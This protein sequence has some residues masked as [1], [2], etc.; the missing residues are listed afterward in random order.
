MSRIGFLF[1]LLSSQ[2][3]AATIVPFERGIARISEYAYLAANNTESSYFTTQYGVGQDDQRYWRGFSLLNAG[4]ND[5][6]PTQ[7]QGMDFPSRDYHF[8]SEDRSMRD[9]YLW[10]TDYNGSGSVSDYFETMLVFLPRENQ[11]HAEERGKDIIVT[12]STG[13]EI[14]FDKIQKVI[15]SGVVSEKAIDL[16][17]D[18]AKRKHAQLSYRGKGLMIRSDA[19]GAD[20]R[21]VK[22][23]QILRGSLPVC[24]VAASK[25]WV[26][27]GFPRFKFERDDEAYAVIRKEC[28]ARYIP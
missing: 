5:I 20:P 8:I 21:V 28:G 14:I 3:F 15:K 10:V 23:V 26:Q 24:K 2:L 1:F 6:V 17:S 13:E 11:M 12:L 25:L 27:G 19:R 7:P 4:M 16:N 9:T 22:E 18:R